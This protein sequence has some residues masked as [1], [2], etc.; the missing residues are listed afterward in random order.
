M[1]MST[2]KSNAANVTGRQGLRESV[3]WFRTWIQKFAASSDVSTVTFDEIDRTAN[4]G[5]PYFLPGGT[6]NA[7]MFSK[8]MV[9]GGK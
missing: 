1:P 6:N 5:C 4:D 8:S 7:R 2:S 9:A 3:I